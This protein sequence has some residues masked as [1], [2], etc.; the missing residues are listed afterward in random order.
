MDELIRIVSRLRAEDGCPWDKIQTSKSMKRC[1]VEE[2]GEFLDAL[3]EQDEAGMREEL[4]D[5]LLQVLFHAQIAAEDCR[6]SFEDVV[7]EE[8]EKLLR[9][10]PHVFGT[11][12]AK[13]SEDALKAWEKSK[14]CEP[15]KK[16]S[17]LSGIDGVPR[18][19]PGLARAQKTLIK[20]SRHGFEWRSIEAAIAKVDE[21][22]KEVREAIANDDSDAVEEEL[23]DLLMA[24]VNLCRWRKIEAEEAMH[25]SIKK[26]IRRYKAMED[27]AFKDGSALDDLTVEKLMILWDRVKQDE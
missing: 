24:I 10:H 23:G 9:R 5:L 20:A 27:F 13:N 4:G 19:M 2:C 6:F 17:R 18:S 1:L 3:E 11:V 14:A 12:H 7:R 16:A 21:E 8:C 25:S 15:E 22:W 26:F